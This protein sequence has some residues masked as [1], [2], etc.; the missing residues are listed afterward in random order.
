MLLKRYEYVCILY[1]IFICGGFLA[2]N[3]TYVTIQKH[4]NVMY[5]LYYVIQSLS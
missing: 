5:F 4:L 1:I 3:D 2:Q